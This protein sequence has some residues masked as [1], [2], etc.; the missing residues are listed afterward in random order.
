[1]GDDVSSMDRRTFLAGVSATA[2]APGLA[3]ARTTDLGYV[4]SH[5]HLW[6]PERVLYP[7]RDG[8]K[9]EA[10]KPKGFTAGEFF[11]HARREGVTR[12]V[13]VG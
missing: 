13:V 7:L 6:S 5:S 12:M 3:G 11:S 10:V 2:L 9:E 1:M 4:D 8:A